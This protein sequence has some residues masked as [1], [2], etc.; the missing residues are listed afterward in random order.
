[1]DNLCGKFLAFR[2]NLRLCFQKHEFKAQS[3]VLI[4]LKRCIINQEFVDCHQSIHVRYLPMKIN[5]A[6]TVMHVSTI[7]KFH[8]G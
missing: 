4:C 5:G 6:V 3:I 2:T 8:L 7:V 1:M